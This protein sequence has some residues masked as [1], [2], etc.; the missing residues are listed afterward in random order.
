[1]LHGNQTQ[2]PF[3]YDGDTIEIPKD[4]R[5][6]DEIIKI[7]AI[8]LSPQII[9]VNVIGEVEKP[10]RLKVNSNTTLTQA[11]LIA[12]GA[13]KYRASEQNVQLVRINR[14]GTASLNEFKLNL[15][16]GVSPEKNPILKDGD[17][18]R[19][20]RNLFAKASDVL[21]EVSGPMTDIMTAINLYNMADDTFNLK[22]KENFILYD[23][24]EET[25]TAP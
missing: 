11:I 10:G 13:H 21:S 24:E 23:R 12:G 9:N 3:L 2:N 14:N 8:N 18:I 6:S 25:E 19:I 20:T 1:M 17:T 22:L 4:K 16:E 5:L 15:K 7:A